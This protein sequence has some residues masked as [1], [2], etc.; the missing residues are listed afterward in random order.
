MD[1]LGKTNGET[2]ECGDG[3]EPERSGVT[4]V[5]ETEPEGEVGGVVLRG[6]EGGSLIVLQMLCVL[7]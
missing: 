7:S 6:D 4:A 5:G 1:S 2:G 3:A